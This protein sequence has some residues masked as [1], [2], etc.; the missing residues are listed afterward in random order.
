[1][2][3]HTSESEQNQKTC[4]RCGQA[5]ARTEFYAHRSKKDSLQSYCKSCTKED[6]RKW[7]AVHPEKY[8]EK[9]RRWRIANPEKHKEYKRKTALK[10]RYGLSLADYERCLDLQNGVC[11]ICGRPPDKRA[12]DVDHDHVTGRV[13]GLLCPTCNSSLGIVE[14]YLDQALA[15]LAKY[16]SS[17]P[18]DAAR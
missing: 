1:M 10:S 18:D 12:L 14:D 11:A 5:K 3:D 7:W 17:E 6:A 2:S 13:R 4:G 9:N 15:Y 16:A 8:R